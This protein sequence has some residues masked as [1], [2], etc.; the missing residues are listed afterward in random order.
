[1]LSVTASNMATLLIAID[2][3]ICMVFKPFQKFGLSTKHCVIHSASLWT[4]A[5]LITVLSGV[6]T[7]R[8]TVNSAC[9]LLG[10]SLDLVYSIIYIITNTMTLIIIISVYSQVLHTVYQSYRFSNAPMAKS[11]FKQVVVRLGAIILTNFVA[12]MT[13]SIISILTLIMYVP[14]S[15]EA[16]LAFI[17]FTLNS[18]INPVLN[19]LTTKGTLVLITN[20]FG[21]FVHNQIR[22]CNV[23]IKGKI[24]LKKK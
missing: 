17:L 7:R 11:H 2:R 5:C 6:L 14:P 13:V 4:F 15:L 24:S 9:I 3:Y 1:M 8:K 19:T 21:H 10:R 23:Y 12:S 16:M 18:C 20:V 22:Y